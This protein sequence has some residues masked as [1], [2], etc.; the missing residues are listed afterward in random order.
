M[1]TP[2]YIHL[3]VEQ[4]NYEGKNFDDYYV[5]A[6]RFFR[7]SPR[8]RSNFRYIKD[9]LKDCGVPA[10]AFLGEETG[11]VIFPSFSDELMLC[12]YYILVHKD[13]DK[14]LRMADMFAG[15]IKR[16]GSLDPDS[17]AEMDIASITNSWHKM[18]TAA[19]VG[20][21]KEAGVSVFVARRK[22]PTH[23]LIIE[24]LSEV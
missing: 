4:V 21:C 9:H 1:Y 3:W 20:L 14:A 2:K 23:E 17:E 11:A 24:L 18:S 10:G 13:C 19:K 22:D 6:W 12:R 15:R 8:E 16:K 7:C 5:A